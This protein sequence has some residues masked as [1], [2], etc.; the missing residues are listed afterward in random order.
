MPAL[1]FVL[2]DA[3]LELDANVV[4]SSFA[5]LF[6]TQPAITFEPPPKPGVLQFTSSAGM[7]L[8]A[9]MRVPVPANEADEAAARSLS[10]FKKGGFT[11]P[12]HRAHLL[13]TTMSEAT[14]TA[15]GLAQHTRIVAAIAE[16]SAAVAIYEG[17]AGATHEPGFYV[18][19]A[20]TTQFPTMLWNGLSLVRT[21]ERIELLSL[22]MS[23][24]AL[25]DLLL[26]APA[27]QGN[28]ALG[29][30]FD[31]LAYIAGRGAR[32]PDGETVGR[33][34][35]EKLTVRYVPSPI[36]EAVEVARISMLD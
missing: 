33:D 29:F 19:V 3:P 16:A 1:S 34:A 13:V 24:L 30:F 23:Q 17:N 26:V 8:A 10:S 14:K 7:T 2:L 12:P 18:D 28:S 31:L 22:G 6:P 5:R 21:Q 36:D 4:V 35:T 20:K 9:L 25:P 27:A 15:A 32:I 11:V